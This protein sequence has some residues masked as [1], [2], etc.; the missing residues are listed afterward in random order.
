MI[1]A[2]IINLPRAI[3]FKHENVIIVGIIPGPSEPSL[4][5]NSYL[6]PLVDDLLNLWRVG[7][8]VHS[9]VVKAALLCVACD[10]PEVTVHIMV[11]HGA[12][13]FFH[14]TQN[15]KHVKLLTEYTSSTLFRYYLQMAT[16]L[17]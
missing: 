11:A 16:W 17:N 5:L 13:N 10:L 7:V 8:H 1:Y 15:V 3:R 6:R 4:H 2:V 12:N 14:M 9:K